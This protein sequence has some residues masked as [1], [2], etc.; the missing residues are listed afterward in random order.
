MAR[1][2]IALYAAQCVVLDTLIVIH[3]VNQGVF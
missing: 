2:Q 1:W 3:L